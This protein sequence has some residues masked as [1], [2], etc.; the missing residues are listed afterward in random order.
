M[1]SKHPEFTYSYHFLSQAI[2][3]FLLA[4]PLLHFGFA[5]IPYWSYLGVATVTA[6]IFLIYSRL[7]LSYGWYLASAP[8]IF[9]VFLLLGYALFLSAL[10]S[11]LLVWR[12]IKIRKEEVTHQENAYILYTLFLTT[13]M[14]VIVRDTELFLLL[15][16]QFLILLF[17]YLLSHLLVTGKEESLGGP[18]FW[19]MI[20][21]VFAA[22]TLVA[23]PLLNFGRVVVVQAWQVIT[24]FLVFVI[25]QLAILFPQ[26]DLFPTAREEMERMQ[27]VPGE[28]ESEEIM[29]PIFSEAPAPDFLIWLFI[30]AC[31]VVL[32]FIFKMFKRRFTVETAEGVNDVVSYSKLD[33]KEKESIMKRIFRRNPKKPDHPI[34]E[35]V[36]DFEHTAARHNKGRREYETVEDWLKRTELKVDMTVYQKV[37]YG[38]KEVT[39]SEADALKSQL[40]SIEQKLEGQGES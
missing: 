4:I 22:V 13:V 9:G 36:F 7:G 3:V 2:I 17:G 6:A 26:T 34:R 8:V 20:A 25:S 11:V 15:L 24:D 29:E 38:N 19:L 14:F 28:Q 12:F 32:Y 30:L 37:R 5:W 27:M 40:K 18:K 16:I 21:G 33:G 31:I 10:F 35:L 39:S 23:I 1:Q